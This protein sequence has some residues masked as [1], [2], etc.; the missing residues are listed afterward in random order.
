L[1]LLASPALA[2]ADARAELGGAVAERRWE[3]ALALAQGIVAAGG[4]D[5]LVRLQLG[6]A[7]QELGRVDPDH[8]SWRWEESTDGGHT[9]TVRFDGFYVRSRA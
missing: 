7:L 1:L 8:L 6:V 2:A 9:W 5:A 3:E 4:G